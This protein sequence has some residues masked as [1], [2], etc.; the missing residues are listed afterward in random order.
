MS[1]F[2][3]SEDMQGNTLLQRFFVTSTAGPG[4]VH[5]VGSDTGAYAITVRL[6]SGTSV[7]DVVDNDP[8]PI[9]ELERLARLA[10]TATLRKHD[11]ESGAATT[12]SKLHPWIGDLFLTSFGGPTLGWEAR[13]KGFG[14][15]IRQAEFKPDADS[16]GNRRYARRVQSEAAR[17][18]VRRFQSMLSWGPDAAASLLQRAGF[19]SRVVG[20]LID[21]G[22]ERRRKERRSVDVTA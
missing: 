18:V 17:K 8:A 22:G 15:R 7:F 4:S 6:K 12:A 9:D 10:I 3:I 19:N 21:S 1:T 14:V 11:T 13:R 5:I 20:E 2:S 16:G